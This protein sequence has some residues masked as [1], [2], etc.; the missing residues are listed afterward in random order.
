MYN[1]LD[2]DGE[3]STK[4]QKENRKSTNNA[5]QHPSTG[6]RGGFRGTVLNFICSIILGI[7]FMSMHVLKAFFANDLT[8]QTSHSKH[9]K[10]G[11]NEGFQIYMIIIWSILI[12]ACIIGIFSLL[13]KKRFFYI[14]FYSFSGFEIFVWLT[15]IG[16]FVQAIF[17]MFAVT[18][19][20]EI[21]K[22]SGI[23]CSTSINPDCPNT[24]AYIAQLLLN[25]IQIFLQIIFISNLQRV[26]STARKIAEQ[27]QL[28]THECYPHFLL[29]KHMIFFLAVVNFFVWLTDS[30][31]RPKRISAFSKTEIDFFKSN[32]WEVIYNLT[33][34]F[35]IF[36][37]FNCVIQLLSQFWQLSRVDQ[38]KNQHM[39]E[40]QDNDNN[41]VIP[42]NI[43]RR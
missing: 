3:N 19:L 5:D 42:R 20:R 13:F 21:L 14:R 12:L 15:T 37:R 27:K 22:T 11:I 10:D 23:N 30:F 33:S 36:F 6:H 8:N 39:I 35:V 24:G 9:W 7:I 38:K 40:V 16:Y 31:I 43:Q 26:I 41:I 32:T 4:D 2:A 28:K 17:S 29:M 1:Y 25:G 34:P 18:N